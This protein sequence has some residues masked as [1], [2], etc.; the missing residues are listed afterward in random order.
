MGRSVLLGRYK[1]TVR[2]QCFTILL[3]HVVSFTA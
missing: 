1:K 2:E 3:G